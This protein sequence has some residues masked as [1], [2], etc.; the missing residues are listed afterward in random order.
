[1]A[2]HTS[3]PGFDKEQAEGERETVDQALDEQGDQ[4]PQDEQHP[5]RERQGITN[6]AAEDEAQEQRELP[7][8][9]QAKK[10]T[11]GGHA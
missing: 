3:N 4:H 2:E 5:Q 9:G 1:M 11:P 7:P 8:R 6:R 10:P